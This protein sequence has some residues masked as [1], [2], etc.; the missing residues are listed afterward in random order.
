ML[1]V[2]AK[3]MADQGIGCIDKFEVTERKDLVFI[4]QPSEVA[5]TL[6]GTDGA[7]VIEQD[8]VDCSRK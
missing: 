7:L 8:P 6:H 2:G 1:E 5:A 3:V 4:T